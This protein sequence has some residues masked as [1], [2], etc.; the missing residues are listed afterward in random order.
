MRWPATSQLCVPYIQGSSNLRVAASWCW[1]CASS[2]VAWVRHRCQCQ[3][4]LAQSARSPEHVQDVHVTKIK[5]GQVCRRLRVVCCGRWCWLGIIVIKIRW[6]WLGMLCATGWAL[7]KGQ[8][9]GFHIQPEIGLLWTLVLAGHASPTVD[10]PP[11]Y[12]PSVT[13][14]CQ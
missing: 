14:P 12:A 5:T 4:L 11:H 9:G 10:G 13:A 6:C 8:S 2:F 3:Q 7:L 1:A